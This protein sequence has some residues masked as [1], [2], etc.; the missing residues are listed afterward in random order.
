[1]K[2]DEDVL[3][4][5]ARAHGAAIRLLRLLRHE[6]DSSGLSAPRLSA[7]SVLVS[8]GPAS[9]ADLAAAE[10]VRPPTMSRIVDTLVQAGFVTREAAPGDRR[11]VRIAATDEGK[12]VMEAGRERRVRVLVERVR[13]LAG[14]ERRALARGVEILEQLT[15]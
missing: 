4:I 8:G 7:L 3:E 9:L 14:S 11:S 2:M 6:D 10:Q 15:R 13:R 5:A 1:M 12:N